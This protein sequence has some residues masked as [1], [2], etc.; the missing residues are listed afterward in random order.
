MASTDQTINLPQ[1]IVLSIIGFLDLRWYFSSRTSDGPSQRSTA[2]G[3]RVNPAHVDQVLQ[4]FPQLD[5]RTVMWELQQNGGSVHVATERV[6]SLNERHA[7][8]LGQPPPSFQPAMHAMPASRP[9]GAASAP[10]KSSHSDLI[11]RYNLSDKI[12]SSTPESLESEAGLDASSAKKRQAWSSN[13]VERQSLLQKRREE[14]IL[15]ARRKM[16]EKEKASKT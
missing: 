5:R 9:A 11:T 1:L 7:D 10:A 13:K 3:N 12:S 2:Q 4:M 15:A 16:E 8:C 6:C 14:M